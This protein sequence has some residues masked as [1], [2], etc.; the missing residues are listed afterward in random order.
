M[1][2]AGATR[3]PT[4]V[5]YRWAFSPRAGFAQQRR[6]LELMARLLGPPRGTTVTEV[7][8]GGVAC[9][10]VAPRGAGGDVLLYLHGGGHVVGSPRTHRGLAGRLAKATDAT[11]VVA[12]Y[13]LAPEHPAPAALE[14]VRSV[15][16]A[17]LSCG[18]APGRIA[19]AGDSAGG[20]LALALALALRDAGRPLPAALG[21]ICPTVDLRPDVAGTRRVSRREVV[22]TAGLIRA[23]VSAYLSGGADASDPLISPLLG[24]LGGLPPIVLH[25]CGDDPL[26]ADAAAFEHR[27]R[28]AGV[29]V[30]HRCIAGAWHDIHGQAHLVSGIGDPVGELGRALR[31]RLS[32]DGR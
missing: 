4:R 15:Y 16:E 9:E 22:L 12:G 8:L 21:L 31:A 20:N 27:A 32:G 30:E 3:G 14:D 1:L 24:D 25:S 23:W 17:L 19:V 2:P 26:A 13:R 6:R 28:A 18:V 29:E 11:A 10:R 5:T 7:E